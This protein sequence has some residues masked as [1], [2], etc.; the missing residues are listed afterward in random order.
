M[1]E[2]GRQAPDWRGGDDPQW[3]D[4]DRSPIHAPETTPPRPAATDDNMTHSPPWTWSLPPGYPETNRPPGT[5]APDIDATL[6][7]RGDGDEA[8]T[9]PPPWTWPDAHHAPEPYSPPDQT[10]A[11]RVDPAWAAYWASEREDAPNG[12]TAYGSNAPPYLPAAAGNGKQGLLVLFVVAAAVTVGA[13]LI[14]VG[15]LAFGRSGSPDASPAARAVVASSAAQPITGATATRTATVAS[16]PAP[17]IGTAPA[18]IGTSASG[19]APISPTATLFVPTTVAPTAAVTPSPTALAVPIILPPTA[20]PATEPPPAPTEPPAPVPTEPSPRPQPTAIIV[21]TV[22][23]V[24]NP[25]PLPAAP[26]PVPTV[27]SVPT[28]LPPSPV[29]PTQKSAPAQPRPPTAGP[30]P[31]ATTPPG[32]IQPASPKPIVPPGDA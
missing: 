11:Q 22:R 8:A 2:H 17:A 6:R 14:F 28:S 25:P 30:K 9:T 16:T 24:N 20:V 5:P 29:P 7:Y 27:A 23:V 21:P 26:T 15:Y 12:P 31:T 1:D 19:S 4:D 3:P 32:F 13:A 18:A 10:D